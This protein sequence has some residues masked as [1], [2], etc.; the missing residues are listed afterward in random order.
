MSRF[1]IE[2]Q[3]I[4]GKEVVTRTFLF[5]GM[6]EVFVDGVRIPDSTPVQVPV[7]LARQGQSERERLVELIKQMRAQE[8]EDARPDETV[9]DDLDFDIEED[10]GLTRYND[11][12]TREDVVNG[13]RFEAAQKRSATKASKTDAGKRAKG[14]TGGPKRT[15]VSESDETDDSASDSSSHTGEAE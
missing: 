10:S 15:D 7:H 4:D 12:V 9:E 13:K 8:L 11:F 5:S 2:K 1:K 14:P 3:V 6:K